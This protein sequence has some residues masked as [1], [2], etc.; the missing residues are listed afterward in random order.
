MLQRSG[1]SLVK[2]R[3]AASEMGRAPSLVRAPGRRDRVHRQACL[4]FAHRPV[5][6]L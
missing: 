1:A 6:A 4:G 3:L 2:T 5:E